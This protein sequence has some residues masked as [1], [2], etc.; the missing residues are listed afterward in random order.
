M[1]WATVKLRPGIVTQ[2]TPVL[3]EAGVSESNLIRYHDGLI[4][5]LGGWTAYP[6]GTVTSTIREIHG[7]A[8]LQGTQF[9][10]IGATGVLAVVTDGSQ[11]DITPQTHTTNPTPNFSISSGSFTVT[12]VDAG[13]SATIYDSVFFNTPVAIGNLLLTGAYEIDT[14]GGS[15]TYTFT[16]SVAASTTI[17]SSGILPVFTTAA[18]S[19]SVVVDLPNNGYLSL[20]NLY[21]PFIAA[22]S[23]GDLTIE[24]PYQV[25]T[26]ID[27]TEFTI[28]A[29]TEASSADTETMNGGL[30]QLLYYVGVG[31]P[32][33]GGGYGVGGYGLGGYGMGSGTTGGGSGT[34]IT[35]SD[36]TMDNWGSVLIACPEDGPI[37]IWSATQNFTT[38]TVVPTAPFFNGGIYISQPQQILVAWR[39]CQETGVQDPMKIRWS[40]AGDYT[41]WDVTSQTAAGS[42]TIPVGSKIMG[43]LQAGLR[44][45]IW[46]DTD[47]W[48][49]QY[50]GQPLVFNHTRVGTGCGLIG[51]HAAGVVDDRVYWCGSNNI[52]VLD[53]N[54]V[55]TVSCSVWDFLFQNLNTTYKERI[56]CAV[57]S[58]FN[59]VTWYFPSSASTGENDAYIRLNTQEGAWDYGYL[60]R[61]AW[62]DVSALGN[63]LGTTVTQVFQHETSNDDDGVPILPSFTT[64]YFAIAE[65]QKMCFV[66]FL[67][68]DMK[69][70]T[71]GSSGASCEITISAVDY[72]GDTPRTYGPVTFTADTQYLNPRLRGRF[73]SMTVTSNDLDS[74]W[75]IGG[76]KYRFAP[77]GRR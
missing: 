67:V 46:T 51:K 29:T 55:D 8:A 61:S 34:P 28:V 19:A 60:Q 18:N 15:S 42:F 11:S 63:P 76:I 48:I 7:W 54:G 33:A 16:S 71:F 3:N 66:D 49:Q 30:A 21:Y 1:P 58:M 64:G 10:G 72:P 47:V 69:F 37:Y 31:P 57:N 4:Q 77:A 43:G 68:P 59:E 62:E 40:D 45:I 65:G 56:R 26:I 70:G 27:S 35:S 9:L 2:Y 24:G 44:G 23:V 36:W 38:A 22:S 39:S 75:R 5:K 53:S 13:S 12:V 17:T 52:Y 74:F 20:P 32:S 73:M 14:V 50:V 6:G 25:A 41:T